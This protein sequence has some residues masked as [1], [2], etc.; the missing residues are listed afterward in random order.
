MQ[1]KQE[2][3]AF[4]NTLRG[5]AALAVV[6]AHYYGVFWLASDTAA[7]LTHTPVL[8]IENDTTS[9]YFTWIHA[10]P[11][12]NWGAYG[13][14]LF[15]L[16]SGFVIPFSLTRTTW[17]GFAVNRLFRILPTYFVGFSISLL[18][19]WLGGKYFSLDW[20]FTLKEVL[21][22]YLPGL[23]GILGSRSI[24]G[25]VWTLEIEVQFYVICMFIIFWFQRGSLNVFFIP[26]LLFLVSVGLSSQSAYLT[27]HYSV[28]YAKAAAFLVFS[29]YV[30][31]M[32]IGVVFHYLH[33]GLLKKTKAIISIITLFMFFVFLRYIGPRQA[34]F[35]VVWS[36]A[37]ALI[38]FTLAFIYP[39]FFKGNK[40]FDFLADISYPLYVVHNIAGFMAL[41]ILLDKG[42]GVGFSLIIVTFAAIGLAWIIHHVIERPMQVTGKRFLNLSSISLYRVPQN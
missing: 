42:V 24:D 6:I 16:I 17:I 4:A 36:Y 38:T 1:N 15:F 18:A 11:W 9:Q 32:F 22:H 13:V 23:R 41:R 35:M 12:F 34:E 27:T 8:S 2:R 31:F 20:P 26:I 29:P 37:F 25:I 39:H 5:F 14:A 19:I 30:I 3:I 21:V 40:I 33:Q 10:F 7:A 28:Y